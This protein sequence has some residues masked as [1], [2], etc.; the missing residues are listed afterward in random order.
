MR[1]RT[2][3]ALTLLLAAGTL[4]TLTGTATAAPPGN[5]TTGSA[6][7]FPLVGDAGVFLSAWAPDG[8]A[9]FAVPEVFAGA[10]ECL[11]EER[12]PADF[13]GLGSVRTSGTVTVTCG[14]DGL[15]EATG[16]V[17]VD[18]EWRGEGRATEQPEP[19]FPTQ[20]DLRVLIR[21]A[22]L[23][24]SIRLDVPALGID[25]TATLADVPGDIRTALSNCAAP[26]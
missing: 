5:T 9:A 22:V 26:H 4:G 19:P 24:G 8:E 2:A 10:Y 17:T 3:A 18:V 25:T 11:T 1:T 23:T 13:R 14:G 7:A 6:N 15:P 16:T 21:Q 20:C 12:L